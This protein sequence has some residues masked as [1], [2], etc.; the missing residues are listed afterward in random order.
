MGVRAG[1]AGVYGE[2]EGCGGKR[3]MGVGGGV[4]VRVG[5]GVEVVGERG[6]VIRGD[7]DEEEEEE[8]CGTVGRGGEEEGA[9]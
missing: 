6:D 5:G 9:M 7:D 2:G 1:G 3:E 8:W 4:G